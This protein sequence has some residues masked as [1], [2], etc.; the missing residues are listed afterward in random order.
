MIPSIILLIYSLYR[1]NDR[2]RIPD[3]APKFAKSLMKSLE[4]LSIFQSPKENIRESLLKL[5]DKKVATSA[6]HI[7]SS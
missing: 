2:L 3:D 1:P 7:L 5:K 4:E 6:T